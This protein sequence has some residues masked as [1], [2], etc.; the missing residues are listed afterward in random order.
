MGITWRVLPK[1]KS[2]SQRD[3]QTPNAPSHRGLA[4]GASRSWDFPLYP[5]TRRVLAILSSLK[6]ISPSPKDK[7]PLE[8]SGNVP[9][10]SGHGSDAPVTA[11]DQEGVGV[12][13]LLVPP[14]VPPGPH[15]DVPSSPLELS[16]HSP[17]MGFF[18]G[19]AALIFHLLRRKGVTQVS[20]LN[21][22]EITTIFCQFYPQKIPAC[23]F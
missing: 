3:P 4:F 6:E 20:R 7:R 17:V 13:P 8:T 21:P 14:P 15:P 2:P 22:K 5:Q 19:G 16:Q 10:G 23:P 1:G 12:T 9:T 18:W 11:V